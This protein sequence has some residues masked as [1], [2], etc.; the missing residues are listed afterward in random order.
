MVA[1]RCFIGEPQAAGVRLQGVRCAELA[2][3]LGEVGAV[4]AKEPLTNFEEGEAARCHQTLGSFSA[5]AEAVPFAR[6]DPKPA[7]VDGEHAGVQDGG[8]SQFDEVLERGEVGGRDLHEFTGCVFEPERIVAREALTLRGNEL[9]EGAFTRRGEAPP[10]TVCAQLRQ[11]AVCKHEA[12]AP[13]RAADRCSF[14]EAVRRREVEATS[15]A[16]LVKVTVGDQRSLVRR[17]A[18]QLRE[19]ADRQLLRGLHELAGE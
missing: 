18:A 14:Y 6:T 3:D 8:L 7:C 12:V 5:E 4:E 11:L 1:K 16:Q 19:V 13:E 15:F 9:G 17:P 2:L 10:L